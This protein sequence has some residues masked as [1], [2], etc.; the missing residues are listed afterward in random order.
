MGFNSDG[1][2]GALILPEDVIERNSDA[3]RNLRIVSREPAGSC[4]ASR[5]SLDLGIGASCK[6]VCVRVW[7]GEID[8]LVPIAYAFVLHEAAEPTEIL[9]QPYAPRGTI[10]GEGRCIALIRIRR[11]PRETSPTPTSEG[12]H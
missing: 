9:L 7:A 12:V 1:L 8:V 5:I 11:I 6:C 4:I 2:S 3:R 10:K